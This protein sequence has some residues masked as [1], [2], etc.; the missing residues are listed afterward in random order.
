MQSFKSYVRLHNQYVTFTA[1]T[2]EL[3]VKPV[4]ILKNN[5]PFE[6]QHHR[7]PNLQKQRIVSHQ[8]LL[9]TQHNKE[10]VIPLLAVVIV[11]FK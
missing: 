7:E 5:L 1:V 3:K 8:L 10:P 2:S 6:F 11:I 9:C 4:Y